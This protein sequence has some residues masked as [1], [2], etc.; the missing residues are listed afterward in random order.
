MTAY[1]QM[2]APSQDD[3]LAAIATLRDLVET[4]EEED[5]TGL[6]LSLRLGEQARLQGLVG[7]TEGARITQ[8][9]SMIVRRLCVGADHPSCR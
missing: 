2:E 9:R 4:I 6:E 3:T 8:R 5:L 7:D 1:Y